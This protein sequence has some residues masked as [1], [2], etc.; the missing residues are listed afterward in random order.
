MTTENTIR[1]QRPERFDKEHIYLKVRENVLK[2]T[3]SIFHCVRMIEL[4]LAFRE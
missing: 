4:S 1:N 2:N 3:M